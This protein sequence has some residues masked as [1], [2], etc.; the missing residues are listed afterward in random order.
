VGPSSDP[1]LEL[2]QLAPREVVGRGVGQLVEL[3]P[4][5][6]C[7][8]AF[9]WRITCPSAFWYLPWRKRSIA[10]KG[11]G[12]RASRKS[13]SACRVKWAQFPN[14]GRQSWRASVLRNTFRRACR[15]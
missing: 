3:E 13:V 8:T 5:G 12:T 6:S 9:R 1:I 10:G 7:A 15:S 11:S 14:V 4:P 2:V